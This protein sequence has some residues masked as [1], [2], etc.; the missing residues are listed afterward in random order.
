M[1]YLTIISLMILLIAGCKK[2]KE[3]QEEID[4]KII[5]EYLANNEIEATK[6]ESGLYYNILKEGVGEYPQYY[7]LITVSYKGY[8]TNGSVFD[9]TPPNSSVTYD[10]STLVPGWQIGVTL[11]KSGG[12]GIFFIPSGL[13]YGESSTPEIPANSVLIFEISLYDFQ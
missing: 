3:S 10:L 13:G 8:L 7:S 2:D 1:K 9:E 12:Q 6:H 5:R 11:L 4:D